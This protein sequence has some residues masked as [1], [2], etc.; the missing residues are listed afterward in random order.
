MTISGGTPTGTN[1]EIGVIS[2]KLNGD[3]RW[4]PFYW[5]AKNKII[6]PPSSVSRHCWLGVAG[7]HISSSQLRAY[8]GIIPD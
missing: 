1:L 5:V 2:G 8:L 4:S 6:K 7:G 3:Q